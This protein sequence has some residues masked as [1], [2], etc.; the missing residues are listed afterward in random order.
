MM[1][2]VGVKLSEWDDLANLYVA[3]GITVISPIFELKILPVQDKYLV[4]SVVS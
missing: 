4:I 1:H 2:K 3:I